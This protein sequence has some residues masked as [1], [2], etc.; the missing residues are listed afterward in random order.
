M[1]DKGDK[2]FICLIKQKRDKDI[3]KPES[4]ILD[5][6]SFISN[7][8][9]AFEYLPKKPTDTDDRVLKA[10]KMNIIHNMMKEAKDP[11]FSMQGYSL[12]LESGML[13]FLKKKIENLLL[14]NGHKKN[15]VASLNIKMGERNAGI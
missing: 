6:L 7:E 11:V 12:T 4:N 9:L 5:I 2:A 3:T 1:T 14:D 10:I 15:Y 13:I 8:S